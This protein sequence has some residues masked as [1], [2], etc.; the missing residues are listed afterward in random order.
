MMCIESPMSAPALHA[1]YPKFGWRAM[2]A[3]RRIDAA[4][5]TRPDPGRRVARL[6]SVPIVV[7]PIVL[8]ACWATLA[9][10]ANAQHA[11]CWGGFNL[12]N[13]AGP[14]SLDY[15]LYANDSPVLPLLAYALLAVAPFLLLYGGGLFALRRRADPIFCAIAL[16]GTA[17]VALFYCVGYATTYSDLANGGFLC[18]LGFALIPYGGLIAAGLAGIV[19]SIVGWLIQRSANSV[20]AS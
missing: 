6:A 8:A 19:G 5:T 18:D 2:G 9:I 16:F 11:A 12:T 20:A 13:I 7:G 3:S 14:L 1:P 15:R 10:V 4:M 17:F